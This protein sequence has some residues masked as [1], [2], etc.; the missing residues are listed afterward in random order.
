MFAGQIVRGVEPEANIFD[1]CGNSGPL[2]L[3]RKK[4]C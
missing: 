4:L 1:S 2:Y 3:T